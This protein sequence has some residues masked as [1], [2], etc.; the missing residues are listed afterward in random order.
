[1]A[2]TSRPSM[3]G[4]PKPL[5][6]R[7][8]SP[9]S[10]LSWLHGYENCMSACALRLDVGSLT[11]KPSGSLA[12][13]SVRPRLT[14][15]KLSRHSAQKSSLAHELDGENKFQTAHN[16][17]PSSCFCSSVRRYLVWVTSNFPAPRSVTRQTRRFVPPRSS[18]RYSPCSCPEGHWGELWAVS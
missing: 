18:A 3:L 17:W 8:S 4:A 2:A 10:I 12:S 9:W 15:M 13:S 5:V 6:H 16:F 1:M 14:R 11:V 7:M